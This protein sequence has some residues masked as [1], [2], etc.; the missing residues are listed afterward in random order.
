MKYH[1]IVQRKNEEFTHKLK[2]ACSHHST[3]MLRIISRK[4]HI[5]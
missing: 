5:S 1:K 2:L 3:K 4:W